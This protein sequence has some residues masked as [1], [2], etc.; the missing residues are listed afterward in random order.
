MGGCE[1][2]MSGMFVEEEE[3]EGILQMKLAGVC[4]SF[5]CHMR[6]WCNVTTDLFT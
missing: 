5:F 6:P 3:V 1:E 4:F 2:K